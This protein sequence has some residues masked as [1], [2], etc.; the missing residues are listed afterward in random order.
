MSA[1]KRWPLGPILIGLGGFVVLIALGIW[2]FSKVDW[3]NK[4]IA[5]AEQR[6]E[7]E[8]VPLPAEPEPKRDDYLR[9]IAEGTFDHS[10]EH[11]FL[12]S[13]PPFGPGFNV[14]VPFE[15][16]SG[17]RV[18]VDRGFVPQD[19]RDPATRA[20]TIVEGVQQIDGV[21]RWPQD[22]SFWTPE[23]DV[24]KREWYSREV[25]PLAEAM[26]TDPVLIVAGPSGSDGWPRGRE[27]KVHI[28][29]KHLPYAIQWFAIAG[30]WLLMSLIWVRKV[31]RTELPE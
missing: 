24:A 22:T 10:G 15:L 14:I 13:N 16:G 19:Q 9:V 7:A 11:Y 18:L 31:A 4:I 21:L 8:P 29:N 1:A 20:A 6:L 28:R 26:M 3:K 27:V 25:G 30:V 12:S 17:K 2:Q 23:A 5:F